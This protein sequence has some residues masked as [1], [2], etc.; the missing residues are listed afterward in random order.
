MVS[1]ALQYLGFLGLNNSIRICILANIEK[2][3]NDPVPKIFPE[4]YLEESGSRSSSVLLFVEPG[5]LTWI[6]GTA[7]IRLNEWNFQFQ[8]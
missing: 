7:D 6:L 1:L 8:F 5:E 2:S 4:S 3:N